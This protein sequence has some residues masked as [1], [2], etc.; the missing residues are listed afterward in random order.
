MI[1][2]IQIQVSAQALQ[3]ITFQ[4]GGG[5]TTPVFQNEHGDD[6]ENGFSCNSAIAYEINKS[7]SLVVNAVYT[8]LSYENNVPSTSVYVDGNR[9]QSSISRKEHRSSF[10]AISLDLKYKLWLRAWPNAYLI[11]GYGVVR[12]RVP[13]IYYQYIPVI[14]EGDNIYYTKNKSHFNY[15]V[16][17]HFGIGKT[18]KLTNKIDLLLEAIYRENF[19]DISDSMN[20]YDYERS[21]NETHLRD[22]SLRTGVLFRL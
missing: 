7:F 6:R 3:K 12:N 14:T 8:I 19:M 18:I 10:L 9:S 1:I 15:G 5:F 20:I 2:L 17:Y 13:D 21:N 22:A 11:A 4:F 16:T